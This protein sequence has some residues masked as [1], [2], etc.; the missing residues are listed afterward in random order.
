MHTHKNYVFPNEIMAW[1]RL[2]NSTQCISPTMVSHEHW[3]FVAFVN[4]STHT[5]THKDTNE[6]QF[7]PRIIDTYTRL[8]LCAVHR[9]TIE[10]LSV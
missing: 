3:I 9:H 4:S 10:T 8:D 7:L 5:H 2:I 1:V 6:Y